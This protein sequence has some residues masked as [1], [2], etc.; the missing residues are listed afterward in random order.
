M[1][2][3]F[4]YDL[5]RLNAY[6]EIPSNR[7]AVRQDKSF[8][9]F[10]FPKVDYFNY[11]IQLNGEPLSNEKIAE[12]NEFYL[13]KHVRRHKLIISASG[14]ESIELLKGLADYTLTAII[15]KTAFTSASTGLVQSNPDI[16]FIPVDNNLIEQFTALYLRGFNAENRD[17]NEV[18]QNFCRLLRIDNL[19]L[20]LLNHRN[21]FIGV[22]VLYYAEHETV[23]AGGAILP[24]Y[25]NRGF[26]QYGLQFRIRQASSRVPGKK[27]V[28]WAY[29]PGISLRNMLKQGMNIEEEFFVYE[30]CR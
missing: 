1:Q 15:A 11:T 7:I 5:N 26:H 22:N 19:D 23:L 28:G 2:A 18:S 29:K 27:I 17:V 25:R 24:E 20:F 4:Q 8:I 21:I 10:C 9:N 12:I 3:I 13:S 30:Y 6:S 14:T 16:E